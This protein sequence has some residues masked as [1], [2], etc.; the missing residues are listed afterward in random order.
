M[1]L[2]GEDY[3]F[4]PISSFEFNDSI[5]HEQYVDIF[6]VV[7]F[8][9]PLGMEGKLIFT[10]SFL[11]VHYLFLPLGMEGKLILTYILTEYVRNKIQR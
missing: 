7:L 3:C 5:D 8:F 1:K 4:Q 11:V 10:A 9:K 6:P 2:F